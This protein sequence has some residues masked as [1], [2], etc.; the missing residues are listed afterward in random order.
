MN[1]QLGIPSVTEIDEVWMTKALASA[2]VAG[3][4]TVRRL[5]KRPI[6]SGQLG[7][8]FRCG[9]EWDGEGTVPGSLPA[10][11]V[12]KFPSP[13]PNSREAGRMGAYVRE[14][15]FYQDLK[16]IA[17]V[18]TP[19]PL[20]TAFDPE[21]A[22]FIV[23]MTDLAPA[24]QG[25]QLLGCDLGQATAAVE[26][27]AG[28]H[29]STWGTVDE[30]ANFPWLPRRSIDQ[31]SMYGERYL[32]LYAGF[33]TEFASRLAP[34]D[35]DL[36]RWVGENFD[37]LLVS[38]SLPPCVVHNDFR[39]DNV[40]FGK[41]ETLSDT[42][43][44]VDWQTLGIGCGPVDVAYF[45]GAGVVPAPGVDDELALFRRYAA[46]LAALGV[47]ADDGELWRSYR[48]GSVSGYIM[49]VIAS[50][51]VVRTE[52]GYKMFTA[53]ASRHAEQMRRLDIVGALD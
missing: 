51:L 29:A 21:T 41:S 16:P 28:L 23:L 45:V 19:T 48:L 32:A 43:S 50:Q 35:V 37:R 25:D 11:V 30:V 24:E 5:E 3:T 53:M 8:S 49:A 38:H 15:G 14:V 2:G 22:D 4:A 36:G 39:L 40:M 44:I 18:P 1:S 10:T 47:S 20:Y 27:I 7:E 31:V 33:S 34:E 46:R 42:V 12:G 6:G 13:D 17:D 9:L 52:R 26:A